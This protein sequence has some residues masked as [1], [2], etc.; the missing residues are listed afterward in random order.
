MKRFFLIV[1]I[2]IFGCSEHNSATATDILNTCPYDLMAEHSSRYGF[3]GAESNCTT[4]IQ[5]KSSCL[6][7]NGHDCFSLATHFQESNPSN[8]SGFEV[9]FARGCQNGHMLACTNRAAGISNSEEAFDNKSDCLFK[10]FKET[11]GFGEPWGCMMLGLQ[12]L[13]NE[14]V[15]PTGEKAK[16]AFE[17]SCTQSPDSDPCK[18]STQMVEQFIQKP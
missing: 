10:T 11:C 17:I 3:D 8:S 5:C 7:G 13:E 12:Y 14:E 1:A 15:D 9:Y 18:M 16:A 6:S 4:E 2:L